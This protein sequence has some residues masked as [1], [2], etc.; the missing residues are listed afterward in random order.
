MINFKVS[1]YTL[2]KR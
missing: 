1:S 2:D